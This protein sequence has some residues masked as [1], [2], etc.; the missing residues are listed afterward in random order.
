M[1]TSAPVRGLRPIPVLRGRTLKMPNPRN[2]I[3]SPLGQRSLHAF[4]DGFHGHLG[5]G[6]R[7]ARLINNCVDDVELNH[8]IPLALELKNGSER[9]GSPAVAMRLEEQSKLYDRIRVNSLS[10]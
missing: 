9:I 8:S 4:K 6:L 7:D 3:R 2:S 10:S 5:L 1:A